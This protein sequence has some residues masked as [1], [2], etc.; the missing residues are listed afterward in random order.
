VDNGV[1]GNAFDLMSA[2]DETE[3]IIDHRCDQPLA[4]V[5]ITC[6]VLNGE[7]NEDKYDNIQKNFN[8][9]RPV[10]VDD[11]DGICRCQSA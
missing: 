2:G 10:V 7:F 6:Q 8:D 5:V 9:D 3:S 1:F 11:N 4:K